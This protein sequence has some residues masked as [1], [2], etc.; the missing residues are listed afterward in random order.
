MHMVYITT[1]HRNVIKLW[2]TT[3]P[4]C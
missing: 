2:G 1:Q 3:S 4:L